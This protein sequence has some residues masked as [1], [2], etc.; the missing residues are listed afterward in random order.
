MEN[1]P[2]SQKPVEIDDLRLLEDSG[3]W[4]IPRGPPVAGKAAGGPLADR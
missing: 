2:E 4:G 1:F 3:T